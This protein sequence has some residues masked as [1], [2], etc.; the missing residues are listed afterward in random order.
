MPTMRKKTVE[1]M[2]TDGSTPIKVRLE[3]L[4]QLCLSEE[5]VGVQILSR[6]L[7]AAC[8]ASADEQL[9]AKIKELDET[10][11]K[12]KA[13]PLRCATFDRLIVS[14]L[15]GRRAHVILQDGTSAFCAVP[16][17]KLVDALRCG[18]TVWLDGQ[19]RALI[20]PRASKALCPHKG[21][22]A[23]ADRVLR[24]KDVTG[25]GAAQL[26]AAQVYGALKVPGDEHPVAA[27][28]HDIF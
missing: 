17:E 18:D 14:E 19:G 3:L 9:A 6:L 7:E 22:L 4:R 20:E 5:Q 15:L 27:V 16:D 23:A 24:D 12:L 25:A 2:L 11:Q 8:Q 26:L 21:E 13:G 1:N 10:L 28:H